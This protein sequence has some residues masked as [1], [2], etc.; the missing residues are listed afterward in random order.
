MA[1]FH[2]ISNAERYEE[3]K[4]QFKERSERINP[5][6]K[7]RDLSLKCLD[8]FYYAR[9]KCQPFFDNYNNCRK[10]W[11]FVTKERRKE[12]IKPYIPPPEE[13]EQ[14]K[15]EYLPRFKA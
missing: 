6:V 11:N 10:F 2:Q 15:T 14:L 5:C 12:G 4:K 3:A 1:D 7:E 13:R 8:E 9:R